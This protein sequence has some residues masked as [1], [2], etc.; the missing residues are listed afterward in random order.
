MASKLYAFH[1]GVRPLP[2]A[3]L[4][5]RPEE[6]F[7]RG[8]VTATAEYVITGVT[9]QGD[10]AFLMDIEPEGENPYDLT[11]DELEPL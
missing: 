3:R 8:S 10:G 4:F 7:P 1:T 9:H 2:G 11:G 5:L 6:V